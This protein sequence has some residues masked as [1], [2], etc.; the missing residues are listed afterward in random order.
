MS[1][2]S[3]RYTP[4]SDYR[5]S[6]QWSFGDF[7]YQWSN[8]N[9]SSDYYQSYATTGLA[10]VDPTI[11]LFQRQNDI[12]TLGNSL[13]FIHN[14]TS[15]QSYR[16]RFTSVKNNY[17]KNFD[18]L[19]IFYP[20]W[21]SRSYIWNSALAFYNSKYSP[22]AIQYNIDLEQRFVVNFMYNELILYPTFE[23]EYLNGSTYTQV[24]GLDYLDLQNYF[25]QYPVIYITKM[26]ITAYYGKVN[27]GTVQSRQAQGP[28]PY[29]QYAGTVPLLT[30]ENVV[31]T[32]FL[33]ASSSTS[34]VFLISSG[35]IL[36][37]LPNFHLNANQNTNN[38]LYASTSGSRSVI[39][40]FDASLFV[41]F[42]KTS[43]THRFGVPDLET[44]KNIMDRLGYNWAKTLQSAVSSKTGSHCTDPN[45][46]CAVI[47]PENN[48]I[49]TTV[50]EGIEIADYANVHPDSNYNWDTG[51]VD[52]QGASTADIVVNTNPEQS[53]VE[54]ADEI[55]LNEPVIATSGGTS[56]WLMNQE[57][58]EE[59]FTYL[60]N[61]DGT[62]FDDIVKSVALL[63]ENP[64]D[65]VISCRF[66]PLDLANIFGSKFDSN[67][68]TIIFGRKAT[69]VTARHL[70]SSNVAIYNL[71]SF[72]FNDSGM[73]DDFR[74]YEPY[75]R[76]SLY[77][78][79]VGIEPLAAIECINKTISIKY[80]IDLVTGACTAV[81]FT[82]GVPYKYIDGMVGVEI[83]VTGRNMAQYGQQILGAAMGGAAAGLMKGP[84]LADSM[85][86][87]SMETSK[88]A[89]R[90]AGNNFAN[91]A[92]SRGVMHG[93]LGVASAS[94]P[95]ILGTAF[96]IA[97]TALATA[98]S[99]LIN[100]PT[101]QVAGSNVPAMGLAK[102]LYAYFIVERSD[103]WI[104]EN[105]NK[106]YGRPLNEGGLVGEFSG[107]SVFGNVK[108]EN[109]TGATT[110]EKTLISKI[111]ESG[112]YI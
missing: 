46:R 70:T 16:P 25:A 82:D 71:G 40:P 51:A 101:P 109:I 42:E 3:S 33:D 45:I 8:P 49:T 28:R 7:S 106:L 66:F 17:S 60:W 47:D 100:N 11:W 99:A 6:S 86:D 77:L 79:F 95:A 14:G 112:V 29:I 96:G 34:G 61:P 10:S 111:L 84:Q 104:P 32:T 44:V 64:M 22:D 98:G 102:P 57:K 58:L 108:L 50:Y 27:D 23:I 62:L 36:F 73:F 37:D 65:S 18:C 53:T 63:G 94:A 43:D 1:E 67:Y 30:R 72:Y 107:F 75:S 13:S 12:Y 78:P 97:T 83:P 55:D 4:Q 15:S 90:K 110:E 92:T 69:T 81:V 80:I 105:Y 88:E 52:Y 74:D 87:D 19:A 89:F 54:P 5:P 59:F 24:T 91:G 26:Q 68:R 9:T 21:S 85:M 41:E 103:S 76:Y 38:G 93:A 20:G 48:K 31:D 56:I 35:N 2:R 39:Y